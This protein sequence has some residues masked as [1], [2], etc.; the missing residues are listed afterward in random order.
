MIAF[1]CSVSE[2]EPYLRY[3]GPG[4]RLAAEPDSHVFVFAAMD[5][6]SR[7]YNLLLA[8]AAQRDDIEALVIVHPHAEIA[9]PDLCAKVRRALS[10]PDVVVVG[11]AGASDVHSIAWWDGTVSCGPVTHAYTDYG[12]GRFPGYSWTTT[13][14]PPTEVEAVDGFLLVLSPWAIRHLRF[15]EQLFLGHG[16][17]VDLCLQARA[18]GKKVST[19]DL[20]VIEHRSLDI[21]S[22]LEL[23]VEAHIAVARKWERELSVNAAQPGLSAK[24]RARR[25]EAERECA[26]AVAYFKRL[27][28]DARVA[29]RQRSLD[30]A[31][32]TAAWKL[33]QP[34]RRLNKWRQDRARASVEPK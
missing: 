7:S 10:Q 27:G 15:D 30:E 26:R 18:A 20:R 12:G 1:G 34:L 14:A 19:A 31:A 32:N 9:D 11:C 28:Y 8:A 25:A 23:W 4:I 13:A 22:D 5:T 3:A 33:T 24:Q 2:P 16:Y 29:A 17:D 6:I 21:I